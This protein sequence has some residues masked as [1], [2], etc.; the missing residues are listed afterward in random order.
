MSWFNC[1]KIKK[2]KKPTQSREAANTAPKMSLHA[3]LSCLPL[4]FFFLLWNVFKIL[5]ITFKNKEGR[6]WKYQAYQKGKKTPN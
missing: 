3:F 4:L 2:K 6:K 1:M 5:L